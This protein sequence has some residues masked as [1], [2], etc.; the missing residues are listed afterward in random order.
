LRFSLRERLLEHKEEWRTH[1]K[2]GRRT[3]NCDYDCIMFAVEA[4]RPQF[5]ATSQNILRS[6]RHRGKLATK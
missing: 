5:R 3:M 6:P 4:R 2:V 1:Q